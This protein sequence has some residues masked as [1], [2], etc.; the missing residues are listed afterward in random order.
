M[1]LFVNRLRNG[2]ADTGPALPKDEFK[3]SLSSTLSVPLEEL[4]R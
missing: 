3:F 1:L 4:K 2:P